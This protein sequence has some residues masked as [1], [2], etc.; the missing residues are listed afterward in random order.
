MEWTLF[1]ARTMIRGSEKERSELIRHIFNATGH[2]SIGVPMGLNKEG[3]PF[4]FQ[5]VGS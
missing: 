5:M 2:T 1:D 4:G 3:L